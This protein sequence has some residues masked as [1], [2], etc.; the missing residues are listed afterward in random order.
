MG[1][2]LKSPPGG[3]ELQWPWREALILTPLALLLPRAVLPGGLAPAGLAFILAL[4]LA[5]TDNILLY[6]C[7]ALLGACTA[8]PILPALAAAPAIL[9]AGLLGRIHLNSRFPAWQIAPVAALFFAGRLFFG[10]PA[11]GIMAVPRFAAL[12]T[13]LAVILGLIVWRTIPVLRRGPAAARASMN[14][15]F[16][17]LIPL[18]LAVLGLRHLGIMGLNLAGIGAAFAVA[19]VS[20]L[21]GPGLGTG[22][23]VLLSVAPDL[24]YGPWPMPCGL[25]LAG[26]LGGLLRQSGRLASLLGVGLGLVLPCGSTIAWRET[27]LLWHALG[28][29]GVGLGVFLALPLKPLGAMSLAPQAEQNWPAAKRAEQARLREVLMD[30]VQDLARIFAEMSR[31]F[32]AGDRERQAGPDLYS[33]LDQVVR[34]TCQSCCGFD[35]CWR[36]NFYTSYRELFD[37][38]AL[39]E[40]NGLTQKGQLRGRLASACI[41]QRKLLET[42]DELLG[43]VQTDRQI[44]QQL[45]E[46]RDFVAS[47]LEGVAG[48]MTNLANEFRVDMEFRLEVEDRLKSSFNRLGLAVE[49]LSVLEYARDLLEVRVKKHGCMNYHE[50][51]YLVAPMVSRLLGHTFTV[52]EKHCP[53]HG[54]HDCSF[55]LLPAG[56]YQVK[57]AVARIA[58][59]ADRCGDSHALVETRDRR[60]AVLLSDGMG[61]GAKA[62]AESQAVVN[63]LSQLISSGVKEDFAL[64]LINSVLMLR[65]PEERFATIDT[66]LID[67]FT[68]RAEL[69]KIGAAPSYIKR[70]RGITAIHATTPPA[71]ILRQMEVVR[72]QH[73]LAVGDYLIMVSDG[74][75]AGELGFEET[76][77][78]LERALARVEVAGPQPLADFLTKIVQAN[79]GQE[80]KDDATII[81]AQLVPAETV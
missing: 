34:R 7:A 15:T 42:V 35:T 17:A 37:L 45:A 14:T 72:R 18:T 62:A 36:Q 38:M 75:Y 80:V 52:R 20:Y 24:G 11:L 79:M 64:E 27:P 2:G 3:C 56:R 48:I 1:T 70:G 63:L 23:G 30:R 59:E 8:G 29:A 76:E 21:G 9:L 10:Y 40:M 44:R 73:Q 78:W 67:L 65:T 50:C 28:Q 51:Q 22:L 55:T 57:H 69:I 43:R 25:A 47:Q 5:G 13:G 33:L 54:G 77:D 71:G 68:G 6:S 41:Q 12:E 31:A 26:F 4:A 58:K 19:A 74:V 60:F 49:S 53:A 32:E 61:T 66:A 81:V 46:S 39:A 16:L